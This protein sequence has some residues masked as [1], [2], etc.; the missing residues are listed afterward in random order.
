MFKID[1]HEDHFKSLSASTGSMGAPGSPGVSASFI[2]FDSA[3]K[4]GI[5]GAGG[6]SSVASSPVDVV[7]LPKSNIESSVG[8]VVH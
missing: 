5:R 7:D 1:V 8:I 6:T 3:L 2:H 4:T